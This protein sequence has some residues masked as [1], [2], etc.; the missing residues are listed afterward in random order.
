MNSPLA[1]ITVHVRDES[2]AEDGHCGRRT[3]QAHVGKLARASNFFRAALEGGFREAATGTIDV[4]VD[5]MEDMEALCHLIRRSQDGGSYAKDDSGR[6]LDVDEMLGLQL[7]VAKF[8]FLDC[9]VED[10]LMDLASDP[11]NFALVLKTLPEEMYEH[12]A[13]YGVMEVGGWNAGRWFDASTAV[14]EGAY[15]VEPGVF[16]S[17]EEACSAGLLKLHPEMLSLPPRAWTVLVKGAVSELAPADGIYMAVRAYIDHSPHCRDMDDE[18]KAGIFCLLMDEGR[19][20]DC[21][22]VTRVFLANVLETCPYIKRTAAWKVLPG[23]VLRETVLMETSYFSVEVPR[24]DFKGVAEGEGR[25]YRL[26]VFMGTLLFL[27]VGRKEYGYWSGLYAVVPY[28]RKPF[29]LKSVDV[30]VGD[31]FPEKKSATRVPVFFR[32]V[33][34]P[35]D[36]DYDYHDLGP[37]DPP[38]LFEQILSR[39]LSK[40]LGFSISKW[41]QE[42]VLRFNFS[43]KLAGETK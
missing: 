32:V 40:A 23:K 37:S 7:M 18:G 35:D 36:E 15:V 43:V 16:P 10:L 24:T 25:F 39:P 9:E 19:L 6:P 8:D 28:M 4:E 11:A 41:L 1:T 13:F 27:Y 31:H 29:K 20:G 3:I 21:Q 34:M 42:G 5:T 30:L 2:E 14:E 17:I 38:R 26:G 22:G 12:K 33:A